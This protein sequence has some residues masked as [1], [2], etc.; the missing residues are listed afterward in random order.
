MDPYMNVL[1]RK[2]QK[3]VQECGRIPMDIAAR[4][5][6]LGV[7]VEALEQR[8]VWGTPMPRYNTSEDINIT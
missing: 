3:E 8:L 6:A 1:L 5:M 4:L 7:D 2:A